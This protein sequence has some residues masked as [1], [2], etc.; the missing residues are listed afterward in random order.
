MSAD[1]STVDKKPPIELRT[2]TKDDRVY[3]E[4]TFRTTLDVYGRGK[5]TFVV[6]A[7]EE[8]RLLL[9]ELMAL[10]VED[11]VVGSLVG[12]KLAEEL[13]P[14][15]SRLADHFDHANDVLT[16]LLSSVRRRHNGRITSVGLKE[17]T[18]LT[19]EF[20]GYEKER[21]CFHSEALEKT[22]TWCGN[23][24]THC[25]WCGR[26]IAP[27]ETPSTAELAKNE[28]RIEEAIDVVDEGRLSIDTV[29]STV[30]RT[31]GPGFDPRHV[32]RQIQKRRDKL[33]RG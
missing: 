25:T 27:A 2:V 1:K 11:P 14:G 7:R 31:L 8:S 13:E 10:L 4:L 15:L 18:Q 33:V 21:N 20:G 9:R 6:L 3:D 26:G 23:K 17:L 22:C 32:M 24:G 16:E 30:M 5:P 28:L 29:H 19:E 12:E